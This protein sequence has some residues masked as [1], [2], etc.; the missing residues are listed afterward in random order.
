M[1]KINNRKKLFYCI[2]I[3]LLLKKKD[4]VKFSRKKARKKVKKREKKVK[5][6]KNR[7]LPYFS[8]N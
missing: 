2:A 8:Q 3:S 7:N 5:T 1:E 4:T 6:D